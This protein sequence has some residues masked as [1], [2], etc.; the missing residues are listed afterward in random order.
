MSR[1]PADITRMIAEDNDIGL[2]YGHYK[3]MEQ[4]IKEHNY[5]RGIEIGT[6]YGGLANHLLSNCDLELLICIDPY[7]YY[8]DM[9]GLFDQEDYDMVKMAAKERLSIYPAYVR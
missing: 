9:P 6:A 1:T 5:K 3:P 4:F 8:P 7:K 2:N